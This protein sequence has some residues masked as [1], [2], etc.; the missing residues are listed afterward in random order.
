MPGP[1]NNDVT[2]Q[3]KQPPGQQRNVPY[4]TRSHGERRWLLH[5]ETA[6]AIQR[7]QVPVA[8]LQVSGAVQLTA[9]PAVQNPVTQ[10]SAPLHRSASAHDVP[11]TADANTQPVAGRQEFVV[12]GLLS[13]HESGVPVLEQVPLTHVSLPS[14][15]SASA[16]DVPSFTGGNRQPP[17]A[18]LHEL[19]VHGLPSSHTTGVPDAEHTPAVHVS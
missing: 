13:S 18:G 4:R 1:C 14:H 3:G 6:A 12:H 17:V 11:S 9:V 5:T 16:H 8:E 15:R 7:P 2:K 19:V 10:V